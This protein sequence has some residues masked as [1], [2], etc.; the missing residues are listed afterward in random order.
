ML[1][2]IAV[3]VGAAWLLGLT[4][5][6]VIIQKQQQAQLKSFKEHMSQFHDNY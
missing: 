2:G 1:L 4:G 6:A 5:H 3:G